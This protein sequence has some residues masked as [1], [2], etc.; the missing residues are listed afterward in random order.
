MSDTFAVGDA[1]EIYDLGDNEW[2]PGEVSEVDPDDTINPIRVSSYRLGNLWVT[3]HNV[4]KP[5]SHGSAIFAVGDTVE[6]RGTCLADDGA[7][8]HAGTVVRVDDFDCAMPYG[9]C[10]AANI[11]GTGWDWIYADDIRK[12][13]SRDSEI[14]AELR[15]LVEFKPDSLSVLARAILNGDF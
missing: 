4:R 1:V 12:P 6:V 5:A 15:A 2:Y 9:V 3:L 13:A 14:I 10:S 7:G 8:W 11:D